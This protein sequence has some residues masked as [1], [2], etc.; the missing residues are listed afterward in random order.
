MGL[1]SLTRLKMEIKSAPHN[2]ESGANVLCLR[3][4]LGRGCL[5]LAVN[6]P[7]L[8]VKAGWRWSWKLC[9]GSLV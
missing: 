5:D 6:D 8:D 4:H 7:L 1:S 3:K 9:G 2:A